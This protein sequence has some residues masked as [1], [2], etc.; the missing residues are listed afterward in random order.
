MQ[1]TAEA[2]PL[3]AGS[4]EAWSHVEI[5]AVAVSLRVPRFQLTQRLFG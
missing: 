2:H 3:L 5:R 4:G 1:F